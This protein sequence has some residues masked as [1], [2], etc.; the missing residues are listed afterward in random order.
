MANPTASAGIRRHCRRDGRPVTDL[1]TELRGAVDNDENSGDRDAA[2]AH[3]RADPVGQVL[4][5]RHRGVLQGYPTWRQAERGWSD[6]ITLSA[7]IV[8]R[9]FLQYHVPATRACVLPLSA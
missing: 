4:V 3:Q 6:E 8:T 2:P 9:V 1:G 5:V 7:T